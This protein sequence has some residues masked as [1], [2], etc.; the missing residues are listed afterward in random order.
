MV[1]YRASMNTRGLRGFRP[2]TIVLGLAIFFLAGA[3]CA[4]YSVKSPSP[5][6]KTFFVAG[7]EANYLATQGGSS[8]YV[9]LSAY[10]HLAGVQYPPTQNVEVLRQPPPRP[11][12]AFAVLEGESG[13]PSNYARM[14]AG[15]QDKAKAIG[16]DAILIMQPGVNQGLAGLAPSSK[17]QA[18]AI[19]YKMTD[20]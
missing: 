14:I 13:A 1:V 15:F 7:H 3:G 12:Q 20:R 4:E 9:D 17:I 6:V 5:E 11:Y 8:G 19:K 10:S 2:V 18:V 16:A